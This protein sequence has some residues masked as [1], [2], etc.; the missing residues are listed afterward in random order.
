MRRILL[1]SSVLFIS[2]DI[3]TFE[4][5]N[6]YDP[7]NPTYVSPSVTIK[8]GPSN[9]E[10]ITTETVAF[11]WV[12]NIEGMSFR[13]FLDGVL[14]QEWDAR[15]KIAGMNE[16]GMDPFKLGSYEKFRKERI[17]YNEIR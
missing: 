14:K 2:C 9:G 17:C 15:E 5:D 1:F 4:V 7:Q 10:T 11:S 13:Y 12:G 6:P 8:S 3:P 16:T